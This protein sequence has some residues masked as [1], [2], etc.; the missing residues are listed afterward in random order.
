MKLRTISKPTYYH[1][2]R[3]SCGMDLDTYPVSKWEN[4]DKK[5]LITFYI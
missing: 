1:T 3:W 5:E 2:N 4:F